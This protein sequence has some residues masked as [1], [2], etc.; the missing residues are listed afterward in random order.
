MFIIVKPVISEGITSGVSC[1][2]PKAQPHERAMAE[3]RRVFPTPGTSSI[4]ICPPVSIAAITSSM[5]FLLPTITFSTLSISAF[6]LSFLSAG[7]SVIFIL[8]FTAY[9]KYSSPSE[10]LFILII[11]GIF[12]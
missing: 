4:R 6:I 1:I 10:L 2:L 3:T 11:D 7:L 5:D 9:Y 8:P 12:G